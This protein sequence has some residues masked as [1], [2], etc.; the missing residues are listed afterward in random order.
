MDQV[1]TS[2]EAP[3]TRLPTTTLPVVSLAVVD[4]VDEA[5]ELA[6]ASEYTLSAGLWTKDVYLAHEVGAKIRS[7]ELWRAAWDACSV[8][9]V[10]G[11]GPQITSMSMG[12]RFTKNGR[13]L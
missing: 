5:V 2:L 9:H 10:R 6:N 4:T 1:R 8:S 13:E 12:L 7:S 11:T 3:F